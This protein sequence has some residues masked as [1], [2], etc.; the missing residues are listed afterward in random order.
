MN[1]DDYVKMIAKEEGLEEGLEKGLEKGRIEGEEKSKRVFVMNLLSNTD[2]TV[3]KIASL[4]N[5]TVEFVNQIKNES[6]NK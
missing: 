4:A 2:F 6:K 5:V 1:I 3:E